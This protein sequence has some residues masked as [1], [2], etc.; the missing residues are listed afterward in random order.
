[1]CQTVNSSR[2]I[3]CGSPS[4][5]SRKH[6]LVLSLAHSQML[7][8]T[9]KTQSHFSQGTSDHTNQTRK[10]SYCT[11]ILLLKEKLDYTCRETTK[12]CFSISISLITMLHTYT[13]DTDPAIRTN[14]TSKGP[15]FF[16]ISVM[17]AM[18]RSIDHVSPRTLKHFPVIA[19]SDSDFHHGPQR[20]TTINQK[21][22][23]GL[24]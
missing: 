10:S 4:I 9:H 19:P 21:S 1:M 24:D 11:N 17:S 7:A 14:L 20:L 22:P 23:R 3:R 13:C 12:E 6:T 16:G 18:R 8:H 15:I 2:A 5:G